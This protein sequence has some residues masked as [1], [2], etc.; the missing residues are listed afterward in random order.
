MEVG[1]KLIEALG[2]GAGGTVWKAVHVPTLRL[3]AVKRVKI[4][5]LSQR[6]Q[7]VRGGASCE[8]ASVG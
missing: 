2:K 1:L 8:P 6:R 5:E 3:V 7:Q 4:H